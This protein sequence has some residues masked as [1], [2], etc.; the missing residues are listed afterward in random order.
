MS[1][2]M[3]IASQVKA[4]MAIDELKLAVSDISQWD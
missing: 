3:E 1:S 4:D 2:E